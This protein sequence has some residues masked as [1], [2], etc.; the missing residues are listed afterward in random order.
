[1]AD[2]PEVVNSIVSTADQRQSDAMKKISSLLMALLFA[3]SCAPVP[4]FYQQGG[5]LSGLKD[6]LLACEVDAL[7]KAPVATQLRQAA[8]RYIPGYRRCRSDGRCTTSGG[9]F[10]GGEVYSIDPNARL[11]RDLTTQCMQ[12]AGY[13]RIELPR[14]RTP[15]PAQ[16]SSETQSVM[17]GLSDNSCVT[18]SAAGAWQ[19]FN[20]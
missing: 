7:A 12:A 18:K 19:I 3:A 16:G 4:L 13:R 14:C 9:F 17:P 6:S 2:G 10:V 20:P 11:R 15:L 8:P 5:S 1:M